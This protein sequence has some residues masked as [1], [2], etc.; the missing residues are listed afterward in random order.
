MSIEELTADEQAAMTA[1]ET[2]DTYEAETPAEP[3]KEAPAQEAPAAE[4]EGEAPAT[5]AEVKEKPPEGFVPHGAMHAERVKRQAL[6]QQLQE[7]QRK[8]EEFQT[9]QQKPA[10]PEP[11]P[12]PVMEPEKF[13]AWNAQQS[14]GV[15]KQIAELMTQQREA[16][17][18][19]YMVQSIQTGEASFKAENPDYDDALTH[20]ANVRVQELAVLGYDEMQARQV[21]QQEARSIVGMAVQRGMNPAAVAYQMAQA[22]GYQK[23]APAPAAAAPAQPDMAAQMAAKSKAQAATASL[24]GAGGPVQGGGLTAE[25]LANMSEADFAKLSDDELR[26]AMGG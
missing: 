11:M 22:R 6:E 19:A 5:S 16:Q 8:F 26:A 20:L 13:A 14:E 4:A 15:K 24:S 17:Q 25:M 9:A 7:M 2:G 10:E 1:M 23:A 21:V 3:A 18:Q 12:D